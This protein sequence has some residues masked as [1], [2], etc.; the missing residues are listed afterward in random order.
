MLCEEKQGPG[1]RALACLERRGEQRWYL[2]HNGGVA[3]R[4]SVGVGTVHDDRSKVAIVNLSAL[5]PGPFQN[6]PL[7]QLGLA[8]DS[9]I[10]RDGKID[11]KSECAAAPFV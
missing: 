7:E 9:A 5:G 3:R 8:H 4:I 2:S 10:G 11:P 1:Q 6:A